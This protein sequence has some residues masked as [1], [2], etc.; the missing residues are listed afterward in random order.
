MKDKMLSMLILQ[1]VCPGEYDH[2]NPYEAC[3]MCPY[4]GV[5]ACEELLR[6]KLLNTLQESLF[7]K[8]KGV[9]D[10]L[11]HRVTEIIHELG[12]PAHVKG[13]HYLR[14]AIMVAV[15]DR[16]VLEAVTKVLYPQVAKTYQTTPSRVERAI[17]H[18]IELSW[19]RGDIDT[20]QKYFGYTVS[21]SKGKPT[22][23]EFIALITDRLCLEIK[24]ESCA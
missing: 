12:V 9:P 4:S 19:D 16:S 23:S 21:L 1:S 22:N 24:Q 14:E 5:H 15:K 17:R 13:Y 8:P 7:E 6:Q 2:S 3:K 10:S 20:I 18:A 11:K